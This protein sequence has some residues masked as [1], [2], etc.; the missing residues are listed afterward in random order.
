MKISS[1]KSLHV[2]DPKKDNF[3]M[4][5]NVTCPLRRFCV[6]HT[7][8][9]TS[10]RRWVFPFKYEGGCSGYIPNKQEELKEEFNDQEQDNNV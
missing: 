6:R 2:A 4:C 10:F 1:S 3:Y 8:R 9:A 7:A 5:L